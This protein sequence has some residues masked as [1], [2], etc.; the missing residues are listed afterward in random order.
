MQP[1]GLALRQESAQRRQFT[2]IERRQLSTASPSDPFTVPALSPV[3]GKIMWYLPRKYLSPL[4]FRVLIGIELPL[5]VAVLALFG[6]ASPNLYRTKLWQ[7][8]ADN[9]FNSSPDELVYKYANYQPYTV[10]RPWS[11]L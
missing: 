4:A 3:M 2:D 6:I 11:Q 9:G 8:G 1:A 5:T 7:D 10:P